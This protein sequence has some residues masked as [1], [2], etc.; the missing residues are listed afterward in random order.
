ML[1]FQRGQPENR[2]TAHLPDALPA[3]AMRYNAGRQTETGGNAPQ[4]KAGEDDILP[5]TA[6]VPAA[7]AGKG[8]RLV[9]AKEWVRMYK[10]Y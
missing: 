4:V 6:A 2:Q 9:P 1:C 8:K 5:P 3:V 10:K 7:I